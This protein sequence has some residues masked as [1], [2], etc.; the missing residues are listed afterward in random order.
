MGEFE[1]ISKNVGSQLQIGLC[2][3]FVL[4]VM[5]LTSPKVQMKD[6]IADRVTGCN[7]IPQE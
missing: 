7:Y 2:V 1:F 6:I 4:H 3:G 5:I